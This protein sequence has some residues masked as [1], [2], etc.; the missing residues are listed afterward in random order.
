MAI[1]MFAVLV[2]TSMEVR[3]KK[4]TMAVL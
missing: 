4:S 1:A 2:D 3:Q